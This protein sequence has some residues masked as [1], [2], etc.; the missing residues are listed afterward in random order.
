[1]A[2]LLARHAARRVVRRLDHAARDPI[3]PYF[4]EAGFTWAV[5][6]PHENYAATPHPA[7][8]A[9]LQLL[10]DG[11]PVLKR[12]PFFHDPLYLDREAIIGR[13]LLQS[14]T[15]EGYPADLILQNLAHTAAPKILNTSA[16]LLEI[17][18]DRMDGYDPRKPFRIAAAVHVY[19]LDLADELLDRLEML[20]SSYDLYVTTSDEEKAETLR[21]ILDRRDDVRRD[22]T[23]VRVVGSNDGRDISALFV[24][25]RD[26][27]IGGRYDLIVKV[28]SKRSTQEKAAVGD[29]FRAQQLDNLLK[30]PGYAANLLGLF[31]RERGLGLVF[32]PTVHIGFPTL[33]GAWFTNKDR[34]AELLARL[35]VHIP[36]D[37]IS[38]LAPLGS[39]YVFRPQALLPLTRIE[40]TWDNYSDQGYADG[41]LAHVQE[42]I[43][44]Y[45]AGEGGYHARTVANAEYAAISHT[46]L[47]Y[48]LDQLSAPVQGYAIDEVVDA[49]LHADTY[50]RVG[51]RL[52]YL[53]DYLVR[54]HPST[55]RA[56]VRLRN[57]LRSMAG[58]S[59]R[60]TTVR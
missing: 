60:E 52:G 8:D 10:S 35:D 24:G 57:G 59:V 33:G 4:A 39:M 31:Q 55:V 5:A 36:L 42:R 34:A 27:L 11:C 30:S 20:P 32:P 54:Y 25:L 14:A 53:K 48:K 37:E 23:E 46:F 2:A 40:W 50:R 28:H 49:R 22:R 15:A 45:V 17:L 58:R 3:H 51:T 12:R 44:A 41:G 16:S 13:L 21:G 18:P 43:P 19:Y 6:Y 7:F 47:E 29:F 1:M 38:P 26:V 56:L 9:A